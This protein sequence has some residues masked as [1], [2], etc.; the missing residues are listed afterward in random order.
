MKD[1][2]KYK[3]LG[4]FA[5][6][7]VMGLSFAFAFI[8]KHYDFQDTAFAY[9]VEGNTAYWIFKIIFLVWLAIEC[10]GIWISKKPFSKYL[11]VSI[12]G[13]IA[14]ILPVFMRM[15]YNP[16]KAA[17]CLMNGKSPVAGL[18]HPYI[19]LIILVA[20]AAFIFV[21]VGLLLS[22]SH[23]KFAKDEDRAKHSSNYQG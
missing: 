1:S 10:V 18:D 4:T 17:I 9:R 19:A 23:G 8:G 6:V 20:F 13:V 21:C 22:F 11:P 16:D 15:G 7:F 3:L 5:F 12:L 14:Q 2:L